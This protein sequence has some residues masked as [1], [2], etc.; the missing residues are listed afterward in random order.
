MKKFKLKINNNDYNV[1]VLGVDGAQAQVTVN[2]TQFEIELDQK[3]ARPITP[4][5]VRAVASPATD[6]HP[7]ESKTARGGGSGLVKSPLPGTI[8]SILVQPG[9]RVTVGQKLLVLEAMKMENNVNA[10][11][12]GTIK[13]IKVNKGDSVMEGDLLMEIGE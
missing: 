3:M 1:E 6:Q 9:D 13:S 10:A 2:G 11:K 4:K 5:L 12:D 7:S 8:L